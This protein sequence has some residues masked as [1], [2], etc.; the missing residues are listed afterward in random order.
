MAVGARP[1]QVGQAAA[2]ETQSLPVSSTLTSQSVDSEQTFAA[3]AM[4]ASTTTTASATADAAPTV[5]APDHVNGGTVTGSVN[6]GELDGNMST[7]ASYSVTGQPTNGTV[8]VDQSG[9][10]AYTPTQSARLTASTTPGADSDSFTVT[11]TDGPVTTNVTV[12]VPISSTQPQL[13][14][15]AITVGS[16]PSGMV[17]SGNYAYVANQG[18]NTV[19]VFD[20]RT[21]DPV[22]TNPSTPAVVDPITV[23]GA[24]T[25]I[26]TNTAGTRLYVTNQRDGTLSV[27]DTNPTSATY[28]QVISTIK[29][30]TS[31]SAVAVGSDGKVYVANTGSNTVSVITFNANNTYKISTVTVGTAPTALAVSPT[32]GQVYVANRGSNT[33]SVIST[34]NKVIKT[35]TVGSQPSGVAITPDG[36]RVYVVNTGGATV[37][38]INTATN[39]LVDTNPSTFAIDPIVSGDDD[40]QLVAE[41]PRWCWCPTWCSRPTRRTRRRCPTPNLLTVRRRLRRCRG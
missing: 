25:G 16:S 30:G 37:S 14:P 35:I 6:V 9:N 7:M 18:V 24:P 38:V 41:C 40:H 5:N 22:D 8:T 15:T 34:S 1:R 23:G 28:N 39:T 10:F 19:S 4:T 3:A 29:V 17:V 26:A 2:E 33:V 32:T 21:G 31:P 13:D 20:T 11:V 36:K 27:I 12:T